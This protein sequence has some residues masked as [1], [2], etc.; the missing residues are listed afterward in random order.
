LV[1]LAELPAVLL[2]HWQAPQLEARLVP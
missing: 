2:E 1:V